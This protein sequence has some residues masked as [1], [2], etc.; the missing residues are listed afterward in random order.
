M[1]RFAILEHRWNGI[2]WDLLLERGETLATWAIDAPL[3]P[4]PGQP[5]RALPDH[6]LVYLE[7]EGPISGGRGE[8]RRVAEGTYSERFWAP[9]AVDL[10][11]S[12][13]TVSGELS[14]RE[15][16]A[17]GWWLRFGN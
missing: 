17:G 14:L 3:T 4:G 10:T 8:V 9:G 7:Y 1:P 16:D 15:S 6:R 2:H 13:D 12:G 5:A 11:L